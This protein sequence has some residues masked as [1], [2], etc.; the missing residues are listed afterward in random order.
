M[1]SR[2]RISGICILISLLLLSCGREATKSGRSISEQRAFEKS[3]NAEVEK[4]I[5]D[6]IS[7]MTLEEKIGQMTQ[8][9]NSAIVTHADWGAG[10]DLR[11]EILVDTAKLGNLLRK[12]HVGSFLN[13]IAVPPET[14]YQFYKGIQEYNLKVSRLKIPIIYGI[15]HMHGP[16]YLEGG[17][18]FPHSINIAAPTIINF[19]PTWRTSRR[20][21]QQTSVINGYLHR[22]WI[23]HGP[24][25]GEGSMKRLVNLLMYQPRWALFS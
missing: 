6:L 14:W 17:T 9:N 3:S 10:T 4:K 5:D 11:I 15:D 12:Y 25:F 1:N 8:L 20:L 21:K 24:H 23:L 13:G 2:Q 18:I 7:Q 19:R 16:T 22:Y